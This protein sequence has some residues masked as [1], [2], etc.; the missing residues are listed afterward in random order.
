MRG[1]E[2]VIDLAPGALLPNKPAYRCDPLAS[3]ELQRQIEDLIEKGY[4]RE[5][6]SPYPVPALLFPKKDSTWRMCIDGRVVNNIT[7]KYRFLMPRLEDMLDD[8][9]GAS[10]FSKIDLRSG[11]HQMRIR[12]G[13]EWKTTFKTKQGLYEWMVMPF[14]LYNAP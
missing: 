1:I 13:D 6:M 8:L 4:V 14:G 10:V 9:H 5:S 3:R 12:E 7:I 2:H 11:Y